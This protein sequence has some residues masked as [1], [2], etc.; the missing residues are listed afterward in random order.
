ME[1]LKGKKLLILGGISA[2][3][4]IIERAHKCGV[5]AYV[6]D[7]LEDSPAKA[8][9][10]KS[11]MVS[12]TDVDAI[13]DLCKKEKI[14]GVFTGNVDL[15]LPYYATI[16]EKIGLPSYATYEQFCLMTDKIEFKK[17][18]RK[19]NV[20][21][22][23]EY[24]YEQ[25]K[26]DSIKY[27]VIVKPVDSSGSRGIS[28][29]GN[30]E[31]LELGIEKALSYSPSKR[32]IIEKYMSG[33]EIVIY[34]YFQDGNPIFVGMCDRYVLKQGDGV[35]QLPTAYV[36]PSIHTQTHIERCH[37]ALKNMFVGIGIKNG[38]MFLQ[39]FIDE[40]GT[41]CIYEPGYR[42]NGAREQYIVSAVNGFDAAQM[43][44]NFALTGKMEDYNLEE[45]NDPFLKGKVACKLSPL[46]R[47]GTVAKITGIEEAKKMQSVVKIVLNNDVGSEI[48]DKKIGTLAQI[49]YRAF[50]VADNVEELK[51]TID[52]L[53]DTIVYYDEN[54]KSM[55]L[56]PF[57]TK[58]LFN[59]YGEGNDDENRV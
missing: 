19:Y 34:Y 58:I 5:L 57:D 22:I 9:A 18:C 27:P 29:C 31:E 11:F 44:I 50:V 36:F 8:F 14:D 3:I 26:D 15:L 21:V 7:Y 30:L 23:E 37:D 56:D 52:K 6:T 13:V 59:V 35:A 4:E 49:A 42:L 17:V 32:Y 12:T 41:P 40:N 46:I 54:G 2:S 25:A 28:V 10:D 43:L 24:T 55:M 51:T 20:P 33:E 47:K 45:K 38:S 1:S 48:T 39:G 16:C 53:H